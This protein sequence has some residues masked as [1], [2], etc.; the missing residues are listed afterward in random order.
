MYY[1]FQVDG[2]QTIHVPGITHGKLMDSKNELGY[3]NS[4]YP[5]ELQ[6]FSAWMT[7]R[8]AVGPLSIIVRL[9]GGSLMMVGKGGQ[10]R[11]MAA[12]QAALRDW[13]GA[14]FCRSTIKI[15]A[16]IAAEFSILYAHSGCLKMP[17]RLG[18]EC[19]KPRALP[20]VANSDTHAEFIV[21][22]QDWM[23]KLPADE[24]V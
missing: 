21:F 20:H 7:T 24:A 16:Y 13:L 18:F 14:R 22:Y 23:T 9:L 11:M 6:K 1:R 2:Q 19:R 3:R 5:S 10:S 17:G 15:R 8:S 4:I 12:Q